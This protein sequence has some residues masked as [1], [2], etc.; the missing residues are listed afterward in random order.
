MNFLHVFNTVTDGVNKAT[1]L[2][3]AINPGAG[4]LVGSIIHG[5]FAVQSILPGAEHNDVKKSIVTAIADATSA[6]VG[7]T[8]TPDQTSALIENLL[9]ALK[10]SAT[11]PA[12]AA[13]VLAAKK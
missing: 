7:V 10:N 2:I 11:V 8:L 12:V 4:L 13:P 9:Q 3:T 6:Q 5:I 1:P